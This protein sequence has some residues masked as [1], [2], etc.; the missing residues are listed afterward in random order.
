MRQGHRVRRRAHGR[1]A[2]GVDRA[3]AACRGAQDIHGLL[4]RGR[5]G[6]GGPGALPRD[7]IRQAHGV[8]VGGA[9]LQVGKNIHFPQKR[10]SNVTECD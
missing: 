5:G 9:L 6:P 4:Q 1:Q 3:A 2:G 7:G 10:S 8:R